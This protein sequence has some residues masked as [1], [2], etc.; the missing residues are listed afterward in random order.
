MSKVRLLVLLLCVA[1]FALPVMAQDDAPPPLVSIGESDLGPVLI[2]QNGFTLYLFT[3]D[4]ADVSNCYERCAEA[5]PPLLVGAADAELTM[6]EGVPGTLGV[7]ERTT[8]TFQVTYNGMPLYY[9]WRDWAPGM[10]TGQGVG[11]VWYVIPPYVVAGSTSEEHGSFLVGPNG[12]TVYSF[13]N[14]TDGVSACYDQC[15]T[16]WP[17]LLVDSADQLIA[18]PGATGELGTTERT[19]GTLQVTYNGMPLYYWKDDA[20]RGDTTGDG[21]GGVWHLVAPA[22]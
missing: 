13:D 8:G 19:D 4:G 14:D 20:A 1:I 18:G 12:M 2:G 7:T 5:W 9:W 22:M 6:G 21:V 15:A 10:T 11:E 16:N 3:R 17:P